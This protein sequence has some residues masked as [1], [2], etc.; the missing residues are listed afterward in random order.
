[1]VEGRLGDGVLLSIVSTASARRPTGGPSRAQADREGWRCI[2]GILPILP[3]KQ[4]AW[5]S[6]RVTSRGIREE[7]GGLHSKAGSLVDRDEVL[8]D[9]A[10]I[11]A[12]GVFGDVRRW[13]GRFLV[14]DDAETVREGLVGEDTETVREIFVGEAD[15]ESARASAPDNGLAGERTEGSERLFGAMGLRG[16]ILGWAFAGDG[17]FL[18]A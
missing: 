10:R 13:R 17:E 11:P 6:S 2:A 15:P 16:G 12:N 18:P 3:D 9:T 7:P 5:G 1:M 14:G 8:A 4:D